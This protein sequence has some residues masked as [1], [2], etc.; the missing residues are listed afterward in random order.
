VLVMI[1]QSS[2]LAS[3]NRCFRSFRTS[4][5]LRQ[6]VDCAAAR[7]NRPIVVTPVANIGSSDR[8]ESRGDRQSSSTTPAN[9]TRGN[10]MTASYFDLKKSGV[11]TGLD[12]L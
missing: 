10:D 9:R 12:G 1:E 5:N 7:A 8:D 3:L 11:A 4:A 6:Q 2:R